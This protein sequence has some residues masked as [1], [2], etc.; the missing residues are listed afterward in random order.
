MKKKKKSIVSVLYPSA[1]LNSLGRLAGLQ[2]QG[3]P[4]VSVVRFHLTCD[5]MSSS[6]FSLSSFEVCVCQCKGVFLFNVT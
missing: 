4:K 2:N 3:G 6:L 5:Y 1:R